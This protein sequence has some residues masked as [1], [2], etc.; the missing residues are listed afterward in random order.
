[1]NTIFWSTSVSLQLASGVFGR[2]ISVRPRVRSK[3]A[4][5]RRWQL[6]GQ[7]SGGDSGADSGARTLTFWKHGAR[8]RT[9]ERYVLIVLREIIF[10][11]CSLIRMANDTKK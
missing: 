4:A 11:K 2:R 8:Q 9:L 7:R 5:E 10:I 6:S 1:M 3:C